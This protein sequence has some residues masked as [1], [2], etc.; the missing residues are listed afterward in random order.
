M[1]RFVCKGCN[2]RFEREDAFDCPYCGNESIEKEQSAS[3]LLNEIDGLLK[4]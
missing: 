3:E 2:Y 1:D 4:N